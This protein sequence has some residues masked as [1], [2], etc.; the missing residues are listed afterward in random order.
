M[1]REGEAI[2]EY[3]DYILYNKGEKGGQR[4]IGFLIKSTLKKQIQN[5]FGISDRIAVL[6]I[7][8]PNYTRT[9]SIIQA[10]APTEKAVESETE[11]FYADLAKVIRGYTTNHIILMGDFNAQVGEKQNNE[12]YVLGRYGYGK[13]SPNGQRL[14]EFLLEHNLTLM[15][16]TFKKPP[17]N[18]W[19]WIS[20]DGCYQNEVDYII[21]NY[22]KAFTDTSVIS[23]LN[24]STDHRMV[25]STILPAPP[26]KARKNITTPVNITPENYKKIGQ[27]LR[28][29]LQE[30]TY[31]KESNIKANYEN[32]EK[33]LTSTNNTNKKRQIAK[34]GG[35]RKALKDLRETGKEWVP[36]LK[37]KGKGDTIT[38]RKKI[39]ELATE[40][41][42]DLYSNKDTQKPLPMQTFK[43]GTEATVNKPEWQT[44]ILQSEV[45]K[46]IKSQ[47]MEKAPGPDKIPNYSTRYARCRNGRDDDILVRRSSYYNS[48]Q[49]SQIEEDRINK[50][51][52]SHELKW[53]MRAN[54][55]GISR[56]V[57]DCVKR[58]V[59]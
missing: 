23:K 30:R 44:D 19:T 58:N 22:P 31:N 26:K 7:K 41:Y 35:V 2:Y 42:K 51:S 11:T 20:P 4:G 1:R 34:T 46:A 18:K 55:M 29:K 53:C 50:L 32:L 17:K 43:I 48:L 15:N 33:L 12:E 49:H 59:E 25:R 54:E 24:F 16:S 21:S 9:W 5:I 39:Q 52:R 3:Q 27:L 56:A 14:V 57:L 10:Y 8:F 13:R 38:N 36:K 47:K 28:V 40:F 6:N 45:E 37:K